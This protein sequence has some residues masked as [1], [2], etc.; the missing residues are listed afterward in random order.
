VFSITTTGRAEVIVSTPFFV[1][2]G[3]VQEP[4]GRQDTLAIAGS[5]EVDSVIRRIKFR[6]MNEIAGNVV[7]SF[8]G[9]TTANPHKAVRLVL[10]Y[11]SPLLVD[12]VHR[13]EFGAV[14]DDM[15]VQEVPG[16]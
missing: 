12:F 2:I 6:R 3:R 1:T 15:E 9:S 7:H 11:F 13:N 4:K 8:L 10:G 5:G 14:E 16:L